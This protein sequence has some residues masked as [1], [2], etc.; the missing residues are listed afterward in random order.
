MLVNAKAD[1]HSGALPL[2]RCLFKCGMPEITAP[3]ADK[4]FF[5]ATGCGFAAD[6]RRANIEAAAGSSGGGRVDRLLCRAP[7]D[8]EVASML[9]NFRGTPGRGRWAKPVPGEA[10]ESGQDLR[11]CGKPQEPP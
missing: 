5:R 4:Q 1:A 9:V 8:S 3:A 10:P 6:K 11:G 2:L 7:F